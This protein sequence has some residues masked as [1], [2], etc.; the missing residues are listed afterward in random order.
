MARRGK[1]ALRQNLEA[2][3][4]DKGIYRERLRA[5][6]GSELCRLWR[7]DADDSD[8]LVFRIVRWQ[9]ARAIT[10]LRHAERELV[11]RVC[12]NIGIEELEPLDET[13]RWE[14]LEPRHPTVHS[15][16]TF[17]RWMRTIIFPALETSLRDQNT[18][19]AREDV[20]RLMAD[21]SGRHI[22]GPGSNLDEL[23]LEGR[24]AT[25][26][27]ISTEY[28][29]RI[30]RRRTAYP[31]DMS[32]AELHRLEIFVMSKISVYH[33]RP[34]T[35]VEQSVEL[36]SRQLQA[37]RCVL[38]LG[39]PG[40]GKTL[41][42][43][44]VALACRSEGKRP[45]PLRAVDIKDFLAGAD[46]P[47]LDGARGPVLLI[48]G[49][50]EAVELLEEGSLRAGIEKLTLRFPTLITSRV[51][52]FED[53]ATFNMAG[54]SFDDVYLLEPWDPL[55]E[56]RE[57]VARLR[58]A[59]LLDDA[60]FYE[61]VVSSNELSRLVRRPLYARMLT[62]LGSD[63]APTVSDSNGLYGEYIAKL[64]RVT[65]VALHE[66][67]APVTG[68]TLR[69]WQAVAWHAWVV[70]SSPDSI[71]MEQ[72]RVALSNYGS[73]SS[74]MHAVDQVIDRRSVHGVEVGEFIH[75][76][77]FEYLVA[78]EVAEVINENPS[79]EDVVEYLKRDLTREMRHYLL[80]QLRRASRTDLGSLL[81]AAYSRVRRM[82]DVLPT[83]RL[84]ACNLIIYLISRTA[85][86]AAK[87]LSNLSHG[88]SDLFLRNGLLWSLCH[89]GSVE[90]LEQTIALLE[91]NNEW[92]AMAR[93]YV[94]YYYGDLQREDGPPYNDL[95][96]Y[97]DSSR[98]LKRVIDMFKTPE[99]VTTITPQRRAIDLYTF[100]DI[101]VVRR[102]S[103]SEDEYLILMAVCKS[104]QAV[105]PA[106]FLERLEVMAGL[107][108]P[109]HGE[110]L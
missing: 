35:A 66:R 51:R 42:L 105:I 21:D 74:I 64:S 55:D 82:D 7:I 22:S 15:D 32:L 60:S 98:S 5:H 3:A 20:I 90:A 58:T 107:V 63:A 103:V 72:L 8:Q 78:R 11:A 96:P 108:Q 28:L 2:L 77:F 33:R 48:D 89:L 109:A 104:L 68:G 1:S 79:D 31:L 86:H 17:R 76:S 6:I 37:N 102:L 52:E 25:L 67:R 110:K 81:Y 24:G 95:A 43:Y 94:L 57:Y 39:E 40:T 27:S 99:Y 84:A 54:I 10:Q 69:L 14:W 83:E 106:E 49:L 45:I 41:T 80:G 70:D 93:G 87:Y 101:L 65:D 34:N 38:L 13:R 71:P 88:E 29:T 18:L 100:I 97:R 75:Y 12:F 59:G 46:W 91:T 36:L 62:F 61:S 92:R 50:D 4:H 53:V 73:I 23:P 47:K 19:P 26:A 30:G 56:F 44:E 9:L 85:K 16:E